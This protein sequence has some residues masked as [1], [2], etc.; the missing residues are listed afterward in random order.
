MDTADP[1][2]ALPSIVS[3]NLCDLRRSE[4]LNPA[5][6]LALT[7]IKEDQEAPQVLN[8]PKTK[9][10]SLRSYLSDLMMNTGD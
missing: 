8:Q 1:I 2:P 7:P 10:V 9:N 4:I 3:S 6:V 5:R